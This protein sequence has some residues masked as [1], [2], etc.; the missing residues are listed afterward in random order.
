[1][2]K[3]NDT[4]KNLKD[5]FF[6]YDVAHTHDLT[7]AENAVTE[8]LPLTRLGAGSEFLLT[9]PTILKTIAGYVVRKAIEKYKTARPTRGELACMAAETLFTIPMLAHMRLPVKEKKG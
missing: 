5:A 2:A 7:T 3:L 1:M 6:R 4:L 8:L 9:T